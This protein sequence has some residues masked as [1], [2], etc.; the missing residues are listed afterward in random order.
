[1]VRLTRTLV[2]CHRT[3]G[4]SN[5]RLRA[6]NVCRYSPESNNHTS[7]RHVNNSRQVTDDELGAVT[8]ILRSRPTHNSSCTLTEC[9]L[10]NRSL[11]SLSYTTFISKHYSVSISGKIEGSIEMPL[12]QCWLGFSRIAEELA[13]VVLE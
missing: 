11:R 9:N 3:S 8:S 12:Q 13:V 5:R 7:V 6:R 2:K 1:M 4:V 10:Q